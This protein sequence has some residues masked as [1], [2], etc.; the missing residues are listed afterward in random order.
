MTQAEQT[1]KQAQL[2]LENA[3]LKAP[4]AGVI[5]LVNIVPGSAAGSTA[6]FSLVDRST[7][8]VDLKL[9]ENDV[10]KATL[11]Q[12]VQLSIDALKSWKGVGKVD[13]IAPASETSNGVVTYRVR[14]SFPDDE[15]RLLVGMSANLSI[16]SRRMRMCCWCPI[17]RC[18]PRALGAWCRCPTARVAP[19]K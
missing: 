15:P 3:E 14:V 6:A 16:S 19:A 11:G 1:L 10:A 12:Q 7:L 5:T 8:H 4:F 13:Y 17:P 2:N 18:C 9:S